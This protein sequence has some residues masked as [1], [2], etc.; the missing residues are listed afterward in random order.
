MANLDFKIDEIVDNDRPLIDNF[1]IDNWGSDIV[2]SKGKKHKVSGLT[3]FIC[4]KDDKI[5]GLITYNVNKNECEIV[6]LDS[7]VENI[8][9]GTKLI[10]KVIDIAR[11]NKYRRIWLI[12]TNDN[13]NAIRFYQKRKFDLCNF[14]QNAIYKSRKLKP[15][16]AKYGFNDI[17]IKHEIEFEYKLL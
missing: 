1:I 4:K 5:L 17:P 16:I 8:G 12:T 9:I 14:Y 10:D 6:T 15:G 7:K 11:L 13:V 3:G 2:V